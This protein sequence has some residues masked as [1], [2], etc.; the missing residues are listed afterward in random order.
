MDDGLLLRDKFNCHLRN[1]VSSLFVN[2]YK[3]NNNIIIMVVGKKRNNII[4]PN[5]V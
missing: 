2:N 4:I 3:I 5:S 1:N